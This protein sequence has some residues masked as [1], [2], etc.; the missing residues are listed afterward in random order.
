MLLS[1]SKDVRLAKLTAAAAS[2]DVPRLD[3]VDSVG[4]PSSAEDKQV[5]VPQHRVEAGFGQD[6]S[7]VKI[8]TLAEAHRHIAR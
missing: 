6:C 4:A 2:K 7:I 5:S 1:H 8:G 3:S